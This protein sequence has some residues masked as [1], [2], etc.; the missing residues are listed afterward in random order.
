MQSP[1]APAAKAA[2]AKPAAA[3]KVAADVV[4]TPQEALARLDIR[5]GKIVSVARHP[6]ADK[7]Y[8]E[9][10]D[11]GEAKPRQIVSGLVDYV[12]ESEMLNAL[13][14]VICNLKRTQLYLSCVDVSSFPSLFAHSRCLS[15]IPRYCFCTISR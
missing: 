14:Y 2:V 15:L 10:I 13:V 7:L 5:V 8:V 9:Q 3:P 1:A 11:V 4:P 6:E 12:P